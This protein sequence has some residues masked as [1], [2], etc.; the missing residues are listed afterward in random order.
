MKKLISIILFFVFTLT[1]NAADYY[2]ATAANGGSNG[3][4]GS[5]GSPWLTLTY[6][7]AH[8]TTSGD[9]IHVT[10]GTY[11]ETAQSLLAIGVSIVGEGVTSI[12]NSTVAGT[13][14]TIRAYSSPVANGNQSISYI[15]MTGS[16]YVAYGAIQIYQ[17]SNVSVHHC[18]FENFGYYGVDFMVW[19]A[20]SYTAPV[21]LATGNTFYDNILTNCGS[22][23]PGDSKSAIHMEGQD[24]L[25]IYNNNVLIDYP[26]HENGNPIGAVAGYNR[27][28]KIYNNVLDKVFVA[29]T[30]NWDFAIEMWSCKGGVEIYNNT[31]WGG[32]DIGGR[33]NEK[34]SSTYSVWVHDNDIALHAM[35]T[36]E[37][38]EEWLLRVRVKMLLLREI[39]SLTSQMEYI[40]H[41]YRPLLM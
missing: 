7:C 33:I 29:G 25:L 19:H 16:N 14:Y 23:K 11:T 27:N 12:I 13:A 15:K 6:A 26:D 1:A 32:I 39:P 34:G 20:D 22:Y 24:G 37:S 18:T 17:R 35:S 3:N 9:I 38:K 2:I 36:S 10:A 41:R 8:A 5:I 4:N 40:A 28:V 31:I 30:T 21:T